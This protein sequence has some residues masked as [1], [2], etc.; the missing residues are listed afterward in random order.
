MRIILARSEMAAAHAA[1][2]QQIERQNH[3]Q[4]E[5]EPPM[6]DDG[7]DVSGDV[8]GQHAGGC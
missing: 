3:R 1:Q 7:R 5:G 2:I 6:T 8:E 4:G